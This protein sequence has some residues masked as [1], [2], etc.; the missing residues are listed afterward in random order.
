MFSNTNSSS[1]NNT[2]IDSNTSSYSSK[3]AST[4]DNMLPNVVRDQIHPTPKMSEPS[5]TDLPHLP[6]PPVDE[7][8][9]RTEPIYH[10][11]L[12]AGKDVDLQQPQQQQQQPSMLQQMEQGVK[13]FFNKE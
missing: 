11:G 13:S 12:R 5:S 4:I 1:T 7:V 6:E 10:P 9:L 3:I 8:K 2:N